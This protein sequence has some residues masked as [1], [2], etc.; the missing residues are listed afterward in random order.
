MSPNSSKKLFFTDGIDYSHKDSK[1]FCIE[2]YFQRKNSHIQILIEKWI[3]RISSDKGGG[4]SNNSNKNTNFS[5]YQNSVAP[6]NKK[7]RKIFIIKKLSTLIRSITSYTRLLPA[8]IFSSKTKK[9]FEYSLDYKSYFSENSDQNLSSN[10]EHYDKFSKFKKKFNHSCDLN[11]G[12]VKI[13][14]Q[15]IDKNDLF[16]VE[17]EIVYDF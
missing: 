8:Y 3:I 6:N 2:I 10:Y 15:F 13:E 17:Q 11:S 14:V 16:L 7:Y 4:V 5:L 1:D 9:G 12:K